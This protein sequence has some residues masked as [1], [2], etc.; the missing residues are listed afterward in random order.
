MRAATPSRSSS[1]WKELVFEKRS[2]DWAAGQ[3]GGTRRH[4]A[5]VELRRQAGPHETP[6][7]V[8]S[9]RLW[10]LRLSCIAIVCWQT[11]TH[12]PTCMTGGCAARQSS[13]LT[14]DSP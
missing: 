2:S 4:V 12:S 10:P 9:W 8:M 1:R 14:L 11:M 13:E 3:L 6:L 7:I 5:L